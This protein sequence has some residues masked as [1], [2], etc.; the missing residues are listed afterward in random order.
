MASRLDLTNDQRRQAER[1]LWRNALLVS[2]FF[3]LMIFLLW[4]DDSLE[5]SLAAAGPRA[6]D[7]R[8]ASGGMQAI[9]VRVPPPRPIVPPKIPLPTVV[10]VEPVQVEQEVRIET[11]AILG[12]RPG[13]EGPGRETGD[14]KGDGG[15][16]DEGLF[17]LVPPSPRGMI[18]P[19]ASKEL[20]GEVV[21]VWVWVDESGRVVPDSTRLR[22]PT[23]DREFNERLLREAAEWVF[24]PARKGGKPVAAWFPYRISM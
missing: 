22:P 4:R 7:N 12:E 2:L 16:A 3:H 10:E 9:Q 20:K 13:D 21:Q 6:G 19:P 1:R 17:R 23:S 24:R 11:A 8:A 14:G 15:T 18:I 5:S